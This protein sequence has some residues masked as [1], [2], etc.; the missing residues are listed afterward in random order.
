[1]SPMP[2]KLDTEDSTADSQASEKEDL[3]FWG[4][5]V[6]GVPLFLLDLLFGGWRRRLRRPLG[7]GKIY[8]SNGRERRLSDL[9]G[10]TGRR[11]E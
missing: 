1:M 4:G 7:A 9:N 3:G 5:V 11:K 8:F 10:H 2:S 6:V